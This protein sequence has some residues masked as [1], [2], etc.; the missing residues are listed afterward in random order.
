M[1]STSTPSPDGVLTTPKESLSNQDSIKVELLNFLT[2]NVGLKGLKNIA[3][4]VSNSSIA[5]R[6]D[7]D[8]QVYLDIIKTVEDQYGFHMTDNSVKTCAY[9]YAKQKRVLAQEFDTLLNDCQETLNNIDL[10]HITQASAIE[11]LTIYGCSERTKTIPKDVLQ[12]FEFYYQ[13]SLVCAVESIRVIVSEMLTTNFFKFLHE[14]SK[15]LLKELNYVVAA[16]ENQLKL[17]NHSPNYK[18]TDLWKLIA[19]QREG[20]DKISKILES[21]SMQFSINNFIAMAGPFSNFT[22]AASEED[23]LSLAGRLKKLIYD[24]H[25]RIPYMREQSVENWGDTP[26]LY[27]VVYMNNVLKEMIAKLA[28]HVPNIAKENA[29]IL[30]TGSSLTYG[31][32]CGKFRNIMRISQL[33]KHCVNFVFKIN[34]ENSPKHLAGTC[35]VENHEICRHIAMN[36][37]AGGDEELLQKEEL[38]LLGSMS[39]LKHCAC[40]F[41][42]DCDRTRTS[43]ENTCFLIPNTEGQCRGGE[44][45]PCKSQPLAPEMHDESCLSGY[46]NKEMDSCEIY[47]ESQDEE[48][49]KESFFGRLS[50]VIKDKANNV[51]TWMG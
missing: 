6:M 9:G 29:T 3:D 28:P 20:L 25:L 30:F 39:N 40:G 24:K 16:F 36:W 45:Y 26:G 1:L 49:A 14:N 31:K 43:V 44:G 10:L 4:L 33:K 34:I 13:M 27:K 19:S 22:R 51:K 37:G 18:N 8:L 50:Q 35:S 7:Q 21:D 17:I 46:C 47:E 41:K 11:K 48:D 5:S 32:P 15:L 38:L 2:L 23:F 12:L 42:S